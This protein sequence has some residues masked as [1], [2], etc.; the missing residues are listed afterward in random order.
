[1]SVRVQ[2]LN[3]NSPDPAKL[4]ENIEGAKEYVKTLCKDIGPPI[5]I[6]TQLL[7]PKKLREKRQ[8]TQIARIT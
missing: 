7:F 3:F 6:K 5:E 1:V 4:R 2:T 8:Y